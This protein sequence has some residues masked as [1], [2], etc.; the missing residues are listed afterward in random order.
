[1]K[2]AER[3][4]VAIMYDFDKTLCTKDMQEYTFIPNVGM[5]AAD[6]WK[7]ARELSSERKMDGVLAYMYLM[8]EKSHAAR[9]G[10]RRK[11][12]VTLGKDLEFFPG[13]TEWF[14]RIRRFGEEIG[15][16]VEHY[17]ISSGLREIIEGSEI[18][19]AFR[20]VFACEFLYDENDV[21]CWPKNAVNYTTKTQFLFRIN[22]GVLDISDD[23]TLNTYTPEDER[24]VP[25]RNMIYIGDGLTDVPCMK[26][27]KVNG[28][29]SIAVYRDETLAKVQPL[30]TDNRVNFIEQADYREGSELDGTVKTILR[31]MLLTDS[32][33]D[34]SAAQAKATK[35]T[36]KE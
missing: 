15:V 22:K 1:M 14:E 32:L 6:F 8:L 24:P 9:R 28:G 2:T 25:F 20:E 27:V 5:T 16:T 26:L 3:P 10:I 29:Y 34:R 36:A 7:E 13:V 12:F 4:V 23:A 31:K 35:E 18:F 19:R 11:D 21:A 17:I 30:L 33:V